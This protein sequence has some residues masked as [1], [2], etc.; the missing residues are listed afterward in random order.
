[1]IFLRIRLGVVAKSISIS[2]ECHDI[3]PHSVDGTV[4]D[5]Q[6]ISY[7]EDLLFSL[8]PYTCLIAC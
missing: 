5:P 8:Q 1:M 2:N 7:K 4:P 6:W 3:T